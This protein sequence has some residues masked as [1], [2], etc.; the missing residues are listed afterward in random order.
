[1]IFGSVVRAAIHGLPVR[2]VTSL[3]GDQA[4]KENKFNGQVVMS[5]VA[6]LTLVR[7]AQKDL[8]IKGR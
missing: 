7:D 3:I 1:M 4:I 6:D 8:G 5:E 2:V